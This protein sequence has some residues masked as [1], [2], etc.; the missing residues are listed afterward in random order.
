MVFQDH[1]LASLWMI[2]SAF[3]YSL[4]N[5][6]ALFS[7]DRFGFWT[8]CVVRGV[9][10]S[11]ICFL[12]SGCRVLGGN[13]KILV[14]RSVMGGATVITLFFSILNCGLPTTSMLTSTSSLWT[15]CIGHFI[16]PEK[17]K[18]GLW[19]IF[20]ALWCISGIIILLSDQ[21][22]DTYYV[23]V[24]SA[25]LSAIFQS[26][27]NLTVRNLCEEPP[28]LVAFWGMMGSVILG[29]PGCIWELSSHG[30]SSINQMEIISLLA[31]GILSSMGQYCKTY[32]IQISP[33]ISVLILRNIEMVFSIIWEIC[34]FHKTIMSWHIPTGMIVILSGCALRIWGKPPKT[35]CC[36]LIQHREVS[37]WKP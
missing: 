19:D 15:A 6:A 1:I 18:W 37:P 23:G 27:V 13:M 34:F 20:L 28:A 8:L 7:G 30:T 9:V 14:L 31:T 36:L 21:Q 32:S 11:L 2:L 24:V 4:Q 33:S 5:V 25:L 26:G 12:W 29:L 22:Q 35:N 3:L 10:G 17:Y 16:S